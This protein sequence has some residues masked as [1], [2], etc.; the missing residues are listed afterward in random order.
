MRVKAK[1]QEEIRKMKVVSDK[2]RG[3]KVYLLV[4]SELINAARYKGS[5]SY[6]EIAAM[7]GLPLQ[8]NYMSSETGQILGEI[9][10]DEFM[11]GR[12]MLSAIAVTL[13]GQLGSGFFGLAKLLGKLDDDSEEKKQLFWK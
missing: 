7:M 5:I 9:S 4:Y 1:Q 8:G 10:E 13:K 11:N 12:P 2:Y 3:S 6:Q